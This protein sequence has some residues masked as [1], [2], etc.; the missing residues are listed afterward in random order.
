MIEPVN[1]NQSTQL[2]VFHRNKPK[3]SLIEDEKK[4][5]RAGLF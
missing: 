5:G 3:F 1:W 2:F 4:P